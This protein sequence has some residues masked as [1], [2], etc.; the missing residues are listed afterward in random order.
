MIFSFLKISELSRLGIRNSHRFFFAH[1]FLPLIILGL[2]SH[3]GFAAPVFTSPSTASVNEGVSAGTAV[4]TAVATESGNT[5]TYSLSGTDAASF[6]INS[7]T[8]VVT[9]NSVPNYETKSSY[10][11]NVKASDTG[12]A[13]STQA[14]TLSVN[15]LPPVITSPTT[16]SVNEGVAAGTAV[17]TA[18]A[19]DP[20]GGTVTYSLSGPDAASFTINST[21]GVVTINNS[22]DFE[23]K[24]S[25]SFS[26][27]AS[28]PTGEFNIQ[29][30]TLSV[31]DLPPVITSP[32]SA[33]VNE[34][35]AAG[36]AVYTAIAADPAGGTVTYSLSG[37]DAAFFSIN[38]TTGVVTIN[39]TPDYETKSTYT[40]NVKASD[41][42]GE[43][44]IQ[45]VTLSV[46]DLPP[47]ITSSTTA[48]VNEGVAAGTAVYTAVAADPAGGTVIYSLTGLDAASFSINSIT[49]VVTINNAPD[50]ETKSS[51]SFSV[52]ASDPTGEFN[53]Q[54]VTLS[55]NDLPPV[56]TSSTTASV[57]EG[58]AAGTVVYTA[59]A[60]DPAGGTVIYSLTGLDA[61]SFSINS[62][63]GVVT[64][65][66]APDYETKSSYNF[67]VRAS[68]LS[69][70]S[71]AQAVMLSVNDLPPVIT[72]PTTASVNTGVSAGTTVYTAVAADPAGGTVT[73]S[74][75]GTDAASF[76]INAST[77]VVTINNTP[78][79]ETKSSYSFNIKASDPSGAFNTKAVT[80][81]VNPIIAST[82]PNLT[83]MSFSGNGGFGFQF[84]NLA[85]A[86][87]TALASTNLTL[88]LSNWTVLGPITDSP[89]GQYH[90]SDPQSTNNPHRFYRVR[91]P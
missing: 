8:G 59:I 47:V 54:A 78:D 88:P 74:L 66:N 5:L 63:T 17:Y 50:Y 14:V 87:F 32:T 21:T 25:Y 84:T 81:T 82:P 57:N 24:S 64:I 44:N 35:V 19:A 34:G 43:F 42:T 39:N 90:F 1:F 86:S 80:V 51:Y 41:P 62:I 3:R 30:V 56:I 2:S 16:A 33:S 53:I 58:V 22:P 76:T 18:V 48:S 38:A 11:F 31:N 52:K 15:D 65:N 68:D 26:V 89:P 27:K 77:G 46:N 20:A 49:G 70:A 37:V 69:G 55:V 45:T 61:A 67:T 40:F 91:S 13:S 72:S 29:T 23:T 85:G 75:S 28:D 4:Y 7:S 71:S 12:G 83:G 79:F 60:A 10:S 73:Y 36:T 6:S 9:I